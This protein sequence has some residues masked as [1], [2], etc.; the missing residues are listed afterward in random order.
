MEELLYTVEEASKIL[1][2]N[3]NYVY[4]LLNYGIIP[5]LVLGRR[6]IRRQA[7]EDFLIKYEGYD[8]SNPDDIKK[9]REDGVA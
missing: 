7:L 6:K 4:E 2:T 8:L 3:I 5:Y 1:K 9:I